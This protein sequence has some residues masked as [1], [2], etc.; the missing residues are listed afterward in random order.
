[1]EYKDG[2]YYWLKDKKWHKWR[3]VQAAVDGFGGFMFYVIG[4]ENFVHEVEDIEQIIHIPF[5]E[6]QVKP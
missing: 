3:V 4:N 5:P 6:S 2:E 1:M